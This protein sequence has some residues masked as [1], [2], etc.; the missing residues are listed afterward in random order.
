MNRQDIEQIIAQS[1][2]SAYGL[3]LTGADLSY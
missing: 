2:G 1:H 3:D